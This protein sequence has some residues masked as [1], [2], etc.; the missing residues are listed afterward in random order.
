MKDILA[1]RRDENRRED[2]CRPSKRRFAVAGQ[3]KVEKRQY[4]RRNKQKRIAEPGYE[5]QGEHG[6]PILEVTFITRQHSEN[7]A[8]RLD[9]GGPAHVFGRIRK[10]IVDETVTTASLLRELLCRL[11]RLPGRIVQWLCPLTALGSSFSYE[12][13]AMVFRPLL[14]LAALVLMAGCDAGSGLNGIAD[15]MPSAPQPAVASGPPALQGGDKIKVTVFGEDKLTGDYEIDPGGFVSLP[16]AGTVRASGLT[17]AQLEQELSKK[18]KSQYLRDPK[19]TVD[20]TT[21]RPFYVL[22]EV[23]KPGEYQYKSGLNVLSAIA[24]AGGNT[25]RSSTS[26]VLIQ[27]AGEAGLREYPFSPSIPILPGD[28]IRVPARYF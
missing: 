10:S 12:G 3:V 9:T 5:E 18:F 26:R 23:E 22:G 16:L 28:L 7:R 17:K 13:F 1:K 6:S 20:I 8:A 27:R 25:Y 21:F 15:P 19:V 24:I 4:R 11:A 14:A 2:R